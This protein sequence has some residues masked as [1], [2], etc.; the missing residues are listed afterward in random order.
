MLAILGRGKSVTTYAEHSSK[1]PR[2]Y[3]V[4]SF[5][6]EIRTIGIEHFM[7][8]EL[9][10]VQGPGFDHSLDCYSLFLSTKTLKNN[11]SLTP[12]MMQCGYNAIA[13]WN[14]VLEKAKYVNTHQALLSKLDEE[15]EEELIEWKKRRPRISGRTWPT[16]GLFSIE[17]ALNIDKPDELYLFGFDF[18][19]SD[20][21]T[22]PVKIYK[23]TPTIANMMKYHL[24]QLIRQFSGTQFHIFTAS[25]TFRPDYPN[26][27][28]TFL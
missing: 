14:E 19:E 12:V 23:N 10:H 24:E 16:T 26:C 7:G 3:I 28:L 21:V 27:T 6:E 15:H 25:K 4:N 1:F 13:T 11:N 5:N 9:I 18:Y 2:I 22:K 8:K 17:F 20:Y